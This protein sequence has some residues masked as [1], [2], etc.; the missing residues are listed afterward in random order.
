M[1]IQ[2]KPSLLKW[3][4]ERATFTPETLAQKLKVTPERVRTWEQ[5]GS[6]SYKKLEELSDGTHTPIGYLFLS[7]P[8]VEQLPIPDFRTVSSNGLTRPSVDLIEVIQQCQLRQA[9]YREYLIENQSETLGFVGSAKV[10]DDVV[11]IAQRIRQTIKLDLRC[12]MMAFDK[13]EAFRKLADLCEEAGILVMRSSVVGS[14]NTRKLSVDEFRGFALADSYAPLIFVNTADA[15]A[16]NS[17]TLAHELAHIW[18]GQSGVSNATLRVNANRSIEQ[19]CNRVAAEVLVPLSEFVGHW[20]I[21]ATVEEEILRLANELKVSRFVVLRR[22]LDAQLI[23][24]EIFQEQYE[25][26]LAQQRQHSTGGNYYYMT[27]ARVS[28]RLATAVVE[29]AF[30]GRTT[31]SEAFTLVGVSSMKAFTGLAQALKI[32]TPP[33]ALSA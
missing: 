9:W 28:K 10:E 4:R 26:A 1:E 7:L 20:D 12:R 31:Y 27:A 33:N 32:S 2:V 18:L 15:P 16:A 21:N 13:D 23:P 17:F 19:F 11:A 3:A 5:T 14:N 22:A 6:I 24:P 29:Q 25:L 30:E 8:P